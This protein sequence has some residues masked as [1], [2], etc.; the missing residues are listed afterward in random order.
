M[1]KYQEI[2][3][4]K[5]QIISKLESLMNKQK[6][7]PKI[8]Q[9]NNNI[10][11]NSPK[12]ESEIDSD[13]NINKDTPGNRKELQRNY[14][15]LQIESTSKLNYKRNNINHIY[16]LE[17]IFSLKNNSFSINTSLLPLSVINHCNSIS[18]ALKEEYSS[19]KSNYKE[20]ELNK[21]I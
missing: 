5:E 4:N 16:S 15:L 6:T 7:K 21:D 13:M 14:P 3:I 17:E 11:F 12:I 2:L 19:F 10:M 20:I 9:E 18:K 8:N 1:N